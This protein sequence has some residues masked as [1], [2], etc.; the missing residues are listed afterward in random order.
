MAVSLKENALMLPHLHHSEPT[1]C[2]FVTCL[3]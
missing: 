3:T 2:H 1:N